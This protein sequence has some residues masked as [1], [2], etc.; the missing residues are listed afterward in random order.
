MIYDDV[1]DIVI[2]ELQACYAM[3]NIPDKYDCSDDVIPPDEV[4]LEALEMVLAY[5]MPFRDFDKWIQEVKK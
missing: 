2:K 4:F 1:D 5:Y 3:N